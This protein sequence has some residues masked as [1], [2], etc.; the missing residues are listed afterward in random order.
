VI[1]LKILSFGFITSNQFKTA[2]Q[3]LN[4][5]IKRI[6]TVQFFAFPNA[7]VT[8]T[9]K[10]SRMGKRKGAINH[11]VY[12]VRPGFILCEINTPNLKV[13]V[14]ALQSLQFRLPVLTKIILSNF[15]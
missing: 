2:S 7:S 5:I 9:A 4:K 3:L 6:G 11:W 1:G 13:G 12:K 14:K 8:V 10:A 15:K